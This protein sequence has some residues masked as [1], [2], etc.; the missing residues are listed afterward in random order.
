MTTQPLVSVWPQLLFRELLAVL[1][2][3]IVLLIVSMV[4]DAPLEQ[5]ADP[6]LT[7][8]PA[9]APWYFVGLQE[10]LVY[11][12][13]WIAGVTIPLL[14]VFGLCALPYVDPS[15]KGE[16]VYS[17]RERPWAWWIF[18]LGLA[19]W[20]FL[21]VVGEWFRG[22][23]WSWTWPWAGGVGGGGSEAGRSLPNMLGAPLLMAYF[24]GGGWF[25]LRK[26]RAWQGLTPA[27]RVVLA[28]LFLCMVGVALKIAAHLLFGLRYWVSFD[29]LHL[30]I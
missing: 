3:T 4:F 17:A 16:G 2:S 13:P 15:R 19:G 26:L 29:L 11:F 21:I 23:G 20:F 12:D 18:T 6:S 14:I 1:A 28:S 25:V 8:N 22:P 9:K 5:P 24:G 7:P 27:R 30:N 10:L